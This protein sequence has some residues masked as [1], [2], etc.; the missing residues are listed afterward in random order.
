VSVGGLWPRIDKLDEV[1]PEGT[2]AVPMQDR[3]RDLPSRSRVD[4]RGL[5][6]LG[7]N[8]PRVDQ[9]ISGLSSP[10][11]R[12]CGGGSTKNK[13]TRILADASGAISPRMRCSFVDRQYSPLT[14]MDRSE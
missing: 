13:A 9:G 14:S 12:G 10:P 7:E 5:R 2:S 8:S 11:L 4:P 1:G 3:Q 6:G